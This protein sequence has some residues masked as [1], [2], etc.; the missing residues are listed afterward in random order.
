[1]MLVEEST[2][3]EAAVPVTAFRA[4]L[5]LGSGFADDSLQDSVLAQVLRAAMAAIEART[6]K[7]LLERGFSWTLV[8]WR[9]VDNQPLPVAP[10]SQV[11]AVTLVDRQG[12]ETAVASI[13]WQL[14]PDRQQPRLRALGGAFPLIP[15]GGAVRI[16]FVAGFGPDW[17]DLPADLAQAVF[18]LA[19]HFYEYRHDMALPGRRM[20]GHV[21]ALI[22]NYRTVRIGFG[23]RT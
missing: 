6:G 23:G 20:P 15:T 16:N 12:Q 4:H 11:S 14:V 19:A 8:A 18:L 5:R 7:V 17:A 13:V 9:G 1:M 10:V 2:V 3:P 22:E 21:A